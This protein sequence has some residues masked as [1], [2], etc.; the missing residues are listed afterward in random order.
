MPAIIMGKKPE[1]DVALHRR[2]LALTGRVYCKVDA[3]FAP[4]EVGDLLTTSP[5]P[6]FAMKASDQALAFGSVIGKAMGRLESG[7]GLVPIL[8]A[9]Q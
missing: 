8:I 9:L 3:E 6:G 5:S 7:R 2:P 4:I 1:A